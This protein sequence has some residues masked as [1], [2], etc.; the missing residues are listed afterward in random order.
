MYIKSIH[1]H[2]IDLV[3]KEGCAKL[4]DFHIFTLEFYGKINW[5]FEMK[6]LEKGRRTLLWMGI[7]FA[8]DEPVNDQTKL[9]QNSVAIIYAMIFI[10]FCSAHLITFLQLEPINPEEFFFVLLQ[11]VLT[12][13]GFSAFITIYAYG[14]YITTLFQNLTEIYEKC[15]RTKVYLQSK[16]I[17][18]KFQLNFSKDPDER[19]T[20]INDQFECI[21][22]YSRQATKHW[23][24]IAVALPS[25]I[26]FWLCYFVYGKLD[27]AYL[28]HPIRIRWENKRKFENRTPSQ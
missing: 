8:D 18:F 6:P 19:L 12:V 16:S 10:A 9:A 26:L 4:T 28:F 25:A 20:K 13:H 7:H 11:L 2:R 17:F 24:F 5:A 27:V 23:I 14:P 1:V 3:V 21:Y 15:K 22:G